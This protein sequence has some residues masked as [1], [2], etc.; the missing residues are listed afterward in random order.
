MAA[1]RSGSRLRAVG[2]VLTDIVVLL[3]VILAIPFVI[4]LVGLPLVLTVRVL[5]EVVQRLG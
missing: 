2:G 3:G 1:A 5:L 4:L